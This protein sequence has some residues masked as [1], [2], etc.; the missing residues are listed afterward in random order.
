MKSA[1]KILIFFLLILLFFHT[2]VRCQQTE[3]EIVKIPE[4]VQSV[5]ETHLANREPRL[6]VPLSYLKTLYFPYQNIYYTVFI[7]KIENR[8]LD[9]L[10]PLSGGEKREDKE[11]GQ[12][13]SCHADFF[14]RI[15]SLNKDGRIKEIHKEIYLP[16]YDQVNSNDYN[17]EEENIY[18]FGTIFP[19][20]RYL[21]SAAAASPDLT[22]VGLTFQEFYLPAPSDFKKNLKLTPLFFVKSLKSISSPDL[23]IILYKNIF[24]Y[25]T[26]EIEPYFDHVFSA[27]EKL[28]I[29][30]FIL[31]LNPGEDGKYHF[32][33]SYTYKKGEEDMVKFEPRAENVPAP[34]VS[35]PLGLAFEDKILEPGEYILEISIKDQNSK[36]EGRENITFSL[37]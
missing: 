15:Y 27:Q 2:N 9:Y 34:I 35:I 24:H 20:G 12:I 17:P 19:P 6:D 1:D 36:K 3:E 32:E 13:L 11:K 8:A 10:A 29:L 33:V 31:G 23:E 22:K 26:L 18:S 25:A 28:D 37:K 21:L 14:F 16:Y 5:M 7:F 4:E 30:Y